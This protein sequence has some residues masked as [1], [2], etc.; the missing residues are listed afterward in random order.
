MPQ[1]L[2]PSF[3]SIRLLHR[4]KSFSDII[5]LT[6][7][8]AVKGHPR[9]LFHE[10]YL[11]Q[12]NYR[13]GEVRDT[14]ACCLQ[15]VEQPFQR[16]PYQKE[17]VT[18]RL[19]KAEAFSEIIQSSFKNINASIKNVKKEAYKHIPFHRS[20]PLSGIMESSFKNI[21]VSI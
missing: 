2:N 21:N 16:A 1:L 13:R 5:F 4:S 9:I 19:W 3:F 15:L 7:R 12:S 20:K 10:R 14:Q 6:I 8:K 17:E 18:N 11:Q